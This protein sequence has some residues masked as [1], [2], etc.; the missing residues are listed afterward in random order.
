MH[1]SQL[2]GK[3]AHLDVKLTNATYADGMITVNGSSTNVSL[4]TRQQNKL[5]AKNAK[6]YQ[7]IHIA[8]IIYRIGDIIASDGLFGMIRDIYK[9]RD[10]Y[11]A[12]V[13]EYENP[14]KYFESGIYFA[15]A[16]L[17]I[18]IGLKLFEVSKSS[19]PLVTCE[20]EQ[21]IWFISYWDRTQYEWLYN[22]IVL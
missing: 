4:N 9:V 18:N 6:R 16:A 3:F 11:W 5:M 13:L 17:D 15:K 1:F 20:E 7:E 22:H 2:L 14:V 10:V 12:D 8:D 21:Y 19:E